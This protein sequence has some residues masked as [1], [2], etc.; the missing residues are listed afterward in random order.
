M[1]TT[2]LALI[3][4][5]ALLVQVAIAGL[6]GLRR[7]SRQP[8]RADPVA[9]VVDTGTGWAGF[10]ELE[11]RRRVVENADGSVCSFYLAP[12][13]GGPLPPFQSGQYL[14]FRLPVSDPATGE[15]RDVTRCYSLSDRPRPDYY[16]V[17]IKRV[18]TPAARPGAP[19]GRGSG[20]FHDQ[21]REGDRL[22]V[23]APAGQF[24]LQEAPPL[25]VVLIGGGIG[26]TPMLSILNAL[27]EGGSLRQVWL[28]YGVRNGAEHVMKQHLQSLAAR[29]PAFHLHVCYS[30][31]HAQDVEGVDYQHCG[32]VDMPLLRAT[33]KLTR[34]QFYVCGPGAMLESLVPGLREWGV[35]GEDIHY[36]S[37]G[38]SSLS[39]PDQ[40]QPLT[41]PV[42]VTFSKSGRRIPWDGAAASLLELAEANGIDVDSG[43]RAG[44]CGGCQTGIE[45]G[46][47][48]YRQQPD[49]EV[50][51]GHCLLCI[52]TPTSDLTLAA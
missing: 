32:H 26:I 21:V 46:A 47:V 4:S 18:G 38:P 50:A 24:H 48:H 40:P 11:V 9:P 29:H 44:S 45:A 28:Y 34:Y 14:T 19:P 31:P 20:Y 15:T 17:S 36:E 16:R 27:L 6:V 49:A 51:P 1:T 52:T 35:A 12:A 43:C 37:F 25:P 5:L 8:R 42:T 7:R 22:W 13:D 10:R 39:Q 30:R 3:I 23:K 2:T 33:L 41:Q